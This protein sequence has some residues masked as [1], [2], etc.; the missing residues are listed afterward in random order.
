MDI[1]TQIKN[2][3]INANHQTANHVA[4]ARRFAWSV[5]KATRI[6]TSTERISVLQIGLWMTS[7]KWN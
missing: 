5:Y 7:K 6:I 3:V 1:K 2:P 4:E